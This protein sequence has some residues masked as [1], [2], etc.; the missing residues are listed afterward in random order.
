MDYLLFQ[1]AGDAY[2]VSL[3]RV[4]E[5][6]ACGPVTRVPGVLPAIRGV[7]GLRGAVIP[8]V[9]VAV[10]LGRRPTVVSRRTALVYTNALV[11]GA[12]TVVALMV[13]ALEGILG[14]GSDDVLPPP[15][16]LRA[17]EKDV[18]AG[19]GRLKDRLVPL[20]DV[21]A[22]VAA[23]RL[24][25]AFPPEEPAAGR[26]ERA[27]EG[28][29]SSPRAGG[30]ALEASPTAGGAPCP[31]DF[32]EPMPRRPIPSTPRRVAPVPPARVWSRPSPKPAARSWASG[33]PAPEL[34][35]PEAALRAAGSAAPAGLPAP[36][37]PSA[38]SSPARA[39][40]AAWVG[41]LVAGG[42]A[43][44]LLFAKAADIGDR[45]G[46]ASV[47]LRHEQL[48]LPTSAP[49]APGRNDAPPS[50]P[51][52]HAV[53]ADGASPRPYGLSRPPEV[54]HEVRAGDTLWALSRRYYG[55][56]FLWPVIF[57]SNRPSIGNPD[58]ITPG[59]RLCI[60]PR[61]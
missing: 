36:T 18:L 23:H 7:I 58:F 44:A 49:M 10:R 30:E 9:D 54:T 45:R 29:R 28:G 11:E 35:P 48:A 51:T 40:R 59:E 39:R 25:S 55:D 56:P 60:P 27:E 50:L 4:R 8:V 46:D 20:L 43:L 15:L 33:P 19:L 53:Q 41:G 1:A 5:V 57:A 17:R 21:D 42:V 34:P 52:G 13:D 32:P 47:D 24:R 16:G 61:P 6:S 12:P 22:L 3:L 14:L 31:A 2:A 38:G 26:E 37:P